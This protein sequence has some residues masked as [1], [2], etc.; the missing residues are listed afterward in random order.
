MDKN[1]Q[2]PIAAVITWNEEQCKNHKNSKVKMV[3]NGIMLMNRAMILSILF[4][5]VF[6]HGRHLLRK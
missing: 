4:S 1:C 5:Y 2:L 6:C 3:N